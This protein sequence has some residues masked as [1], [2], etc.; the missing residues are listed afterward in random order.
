VNALADLEAPGVAFVSLKDNV[1]LSTPSGRL[2]FQIIGASLR[3]IVLE[4][5]SGG[6]GEHLS[7]SVNKSESDRRSGS[8]PNRSNGAGGLLFGTR[9]DRRDKKS[10]RALN[11]AARNTD[12]PSLNFS[13]LAFIT[14][15]PCV[16][17]QQIKS[18][19]CNSNSLVLLGL[20]VKSRLKVL[21]WT[22][23]VGLDAAILAGRGESI[24]SHA[25]T[26]LDEG[27]DF[28]HLENLP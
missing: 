25:A 16:V 19:G 12:G 5:S 21:F 23:N 2:M 28:P 27:L 13:V 14:H 15:L 4:R 11:Q 24:G 8:V 10:L 22:Q 20:E 1:D 18:S 9:G 17:T 26:V 6:S 7:G 3:V